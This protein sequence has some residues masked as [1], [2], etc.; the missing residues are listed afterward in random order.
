MFTGT[1]YTF[2]QMVIIWSVVT[3]I[4]G[5]SLLIA[6]KIAHIELEPLEKWIVILLTSLT[7]L[8]PAIGPFVAPVV[9]IY[10]INRMADAEL[11][12]IIGAVLITRFISVLVAIGLERVL[13]SVGFLNR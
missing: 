13:A 12:I 3:V 6:L 11:P 4:W 9:A 5:V 8:F 7:A 10:L 1:E 2:A